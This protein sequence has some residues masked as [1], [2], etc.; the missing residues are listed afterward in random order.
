M[1]LENSY[2]GKLI[3][4]KDRY[5]STHKGGNGIGLVSVIATAEK[6]DGTASFSHDDY[7]FNPISC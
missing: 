6:Y 4:I 7:V 1:A 3:K 2:G 5:L